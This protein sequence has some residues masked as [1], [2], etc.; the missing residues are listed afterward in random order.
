MDPIISVALL[1]AIPSLP[2]DA[3]ELEEVGPPHRDASFKPR[4]PP[5]MTG[6]SAIC[7]GTF[8]LQALA[9]D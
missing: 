7:N 3:F 9:T 6:N 1:E 8:A 4:T 5:A 2:Y